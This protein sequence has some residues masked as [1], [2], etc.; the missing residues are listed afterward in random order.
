M[1]QSCTNCHQYEPH[2]ESLHLLKK[3]STVTGYCL[4]NG[5]QVEPDEHCP[6]FKRAIS[7]SSSSK[8]DR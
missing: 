7:H 8:G 1:N 6:Y 4:F 2:Q 3:S 5:W